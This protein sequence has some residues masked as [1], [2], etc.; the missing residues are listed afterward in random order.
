MLKVTINKAGT[1]S[2]K[3]SA[4]ALKSAAVMSPELETYDEKSGRHLA[5]CIPDAKLFAKDILN[6]LH[7]E[8]EDGTTP[9]H[10]LFDGA[11]EKLTHVGS[12]AILMPGDPG[13]RRKF[14]D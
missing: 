2:I 4:A 10:R 7:D 5:P 3:I 1:I 8:A 11:F 9:V 6:A 13:Y 14:V 12:E